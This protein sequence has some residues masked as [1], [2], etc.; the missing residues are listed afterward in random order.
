MA[1]QVS[2]MD[3]GGDRLTIG[4]VQ[5]LLA[6]GKKPGDVIVTIVDYND[7]TERLVREGWISAAMV[8]VPVT[9]GRWGIR[10]AVLALEKKPIP[11]NL[12][13]PIY[14]VTKDNA[15]QIDVT[16][17]RQPEGWR[18]PLPSGWPRPTMHVLIAPLGGPTMRR[19][20][21]VLLLLA[22][23]LP[24]D[25]P[26]QAPAV[27]IGLLLPYTG[28]LSVQGIDTTNGFE[29]YLTKIGRKAGGR[30]IEVLKEDDEAKPDVAL[31]KIK[32]L[33]ERDHVDFLVGPVSSVVAVAIR[34]YVHEQQTPLIVPV[35]FTRVLTSPQQASPSIFRIAETTDQSNYPMGAWMMKNTKYRRVVVMAT[36]FVAGRHAVEAFI[37]GF[38]AAGGDIVKEIYPPLNTPDFAPYLAQAG[39]EKADAVYAWFAGADAIRFVKQ[40]REYGIGE[41]MPL[42]GH[43]VLVD[44]TIMPAV[45]DAALGI[46]TMGSYTST[47]DN[48]ENKAFVAEYDKRYKTWPSR[49]SDAGWMTLELIAQALDDLKGDLSHRDKVR[50]AL[51]N[52]LPKLKTPRGHLEFDQY[53]QVI[54]P[55]YVTRAEKVGGRYVNTVIERIPNVR[56]EDVWGWWNKK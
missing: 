54:T 35:A 5:A 37:A 32:K 2:Q 15:D 45:G 30:A 29:L 12:L 46:V 1:K 38:K 56:Q 24:F 28:V 33:V 50:E 27:K 4:A 6:Q 10:V 11:P 19:W 23:V 47:L 41:K 22:L 48:P 7:D 3:P 26:A 8:Q 13:T 31:T 44:D 55:I 16:G 34:S 25:A 17:V 40:Y 49:Y 36:D 20:L 9:M 39:A 21:P 14:V 42:T 43:A 51:K 53:R 52:A 18:P